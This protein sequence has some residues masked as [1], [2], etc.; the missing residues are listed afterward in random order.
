[1]SSSIFVLRFS[2]IDKY[3][4]LN[5]IQLSSFTHVEIMG[6]GQQI[7]AIFGYEGPA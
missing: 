6:F 7:R 4:A 5:H 1:M 3:A 2:F